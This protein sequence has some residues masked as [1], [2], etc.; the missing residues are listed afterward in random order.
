MQ[1]DLKGKVAVITG[2]GEGIGRELAGQMALNG[3]KIVLNDVDEAKAELACDGIRAQG[4]DCIPLPGD[5]GDLDDI[6][7]LVEVAVKNFGRLDLAIANAGITSYGGF[8][9][10][11]PERFRELLH[12]NLQGSFFLAQQAARQM[13]KQAEGGSILL[14]SSVTGQQSH[15]NL[16]AYGMT[17]AAIDMLVKALVLELSPLAIRINAV[18]PGATLTNRTLQLEENFEATWSAITPMRKAATTV[19]IANAALFLLSDSAG[20]VTG[21]TLTVDG[22]FTAL[23]VDPSLFQSK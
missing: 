3:A 19:D 13:R 10:F 8:F 15:H 2:A 7:A 14:M 6:Q 18:A 21:Q 22:G 1:I 16:A 5:A 4:G 20:H 23:C 9:D 12:V 17:K 11:E